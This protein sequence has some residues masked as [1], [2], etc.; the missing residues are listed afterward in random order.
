MNPADQRWSSLLVE[1]QV[2]VLRH[3]PCF[4]SSPLFPSF[5]LSLPTTAAV[6]SP[7][8]P[9]WHCFGDQSH[10]LPLL[11]SS[12]SLPSHGQTV[13]GASRLG[14]SRQ[15]SPTRPPR[16]VSLSL[17]SVARFSM[18]GDGGLRGAERVRESEMR[19]MSSG[20]VSWVMNP[21]FLYF[22]FSFIISVIVICFIL[23]V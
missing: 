10:V 22:N 4:C 23:F 13:V 11:C 17:L 12:H 14:R 9:P 3:W 7:V 2:R 19:E 6:V 20:E 18:M 8:R 16:P 21:P 15:G 5:V 1:V